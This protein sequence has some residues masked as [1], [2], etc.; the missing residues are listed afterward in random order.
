[1]LERFNTY[2]TLKAFRA[3]NFCDTSSDYLQLNY[4]HD[5]IMRKV[6]QIAITQVH[7]DHGPPSTPFAFFVMG[8]A[9]RFEQGAYSDQDHGI[10]YKEASTEA[11]KY[12][13]YLGNE[14]TRGL[15]IV[16]YKRCEGNVMCSNPLWCKSEKEWKDQIHHW[17]TEQ[18][19]ESIRH[20]LIFMDARN[21]VGDVTSIERLKELIFTTAMESPLLLRRMF[22]NTLH[23]KNGL[24]LLGQFLE[25]T[26]GRYAGTINLKETAFF[27]YVNAIRLLSIKENIKIT[28]TIQRIE[29]LCEFPLYPPILTN[30]RSDFFQLLKIRHSLQISST[31]CS[32][33]A[34]HYINPY[35]LSIENRHD[36]KKIL[37]NAFQ[38]HKQLEKFID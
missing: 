1:M 24:G 37:R 5:Q 10:V 4:L 14:I 28:A 21:L 22:E 31:P 6:I 17:I 13:Q 30:A 19:W 9:G 8:S 25:V 36:L 33:T 3:Q 7:L 27:P 12:Y 11:T 32:N 35:Q 15:E 34:G 18:D 20:L 26:H 2:Q 38:L 29:K 16:G 23:I